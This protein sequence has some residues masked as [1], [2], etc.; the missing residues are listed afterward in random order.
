MENVLEINV[1]DT[2]TT[3]DTLVDAIEY[4]VEQI[5][6][7]FASEDPKPLNISLNRMT[8]RGPPTLKIFVADQV[9][10]EGGLV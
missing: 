5:K 8:N 10:T 3:F 7:W 6:K 2:I 9:G 4:V 1:F